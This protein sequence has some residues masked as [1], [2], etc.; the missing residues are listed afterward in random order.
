MPEL[1]QQPGTIEEALANGRML[2]SEQPAAAL[3]QAQA[4]LRAH[5]GHAP[6]MRLAAA[7]H[8][9]LGEDQHARRAELSALQAGESD[10]AL[11]AVAKALG[12]RQ[13]DEASRLAAEHLARWPDD[14]AAMT[15]SAEAAIALGVADK[16]LPLLDEVLERAPDF[17]PALMLR[18]SALIQMDRLAEAQSAI[19]AQIEREPSSIA[20]HQL[21]SRIS[22]EAGDWEQVVATG[23][24]IV[25]REEATCDDWVSYGDGLRFAGDK[26]KALAAY[27]KALSLE[28]EHGRAWWSLTDID[29]QALGHEDVTAMEA[30]LAVRADEPDHAS[31]LHFALGMVRD[32]QSDHARAFAQFEAGNALRRKAQPYDAREL[33]EQV[34]RWIEAFG[35]PDILPASP[36]QSDGAN[37]IFILG[38][39]R[40]GSTLLERALGMHSEIEPL[41]ELAIMPNLAKRLERDHEDIEQA[42]A[43]MPPEEIE[44]VGARYIERASERMT[45]EAGFF[46]DKLHM[47]WK[48]LAVIL[49]ALPQA[50]VIDLRR[51]PMDCCWS[52]YRTL[53]ARGHPA[54]SDLE[55][56]G[57]FYRDYARQ[58]DHF[59][60]LA[61]GRVTRVSYER[62]VDAFEPVVR[63]VLAFCGLRFE[64]TCLEFHTSSAPVATAS[65]EQV[66]EPLN[67]KGI[68]AWEPYDEWL[69]PLRKGLGLTA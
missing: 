21:L 18:I 29:T 15:M 26:A 53:F 57:R 28:P 42:V 48:H 1:A 40:A 23:E 14:L 13:F 36:P 66:R 4:I 37:P 41:G 7:A 61:P 69:G 30:A 49:R 25:D 22:S 33:S 31:N 6:A 55:D 68:G 54:A 56:I 63:S 27:R 59:R 2:L 60:R 65:S 50:K 8:R 12:A 35:S 9:A 3:A 51:D 67:R 11:Q 64:P 62:L 32:K 38:M 24:Q 39:P 17:R 5:R 46:V 58:T 45:S 19:R 44:A 10:P 34:D 16:G 43:Q 47:N 20:Q 52:N